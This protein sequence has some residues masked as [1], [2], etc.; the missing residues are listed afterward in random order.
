MS[1]RVAVLVIALSSVALAQQPARD[2]AGQR[3]TGTATISGIVM[4][5]EAQ[6]K[7]V[8]RAR[9]TLNSAE[10][11]HGRTEITHDDGTF[12]FRGLPAGQYRVGVTKDA[13]LFTNYGETRPGRPGTPIALRAGES[14]ELTLRL[15]RGSVITGTVVTADGQP[16]PG[17]QV[18]AFSMRYIPALGERRQQP[19]AMSGL[20]DD[21][22]VYRIFRLAPGDYMVAATQMRPMSNP[23]ELQRLTDAEIRRALSDVRES[24]RRSTPGVPVTPRNVKPPPPPP[25]ARSLTYAPVYY[26]GTPNASLAGRVTLGKSEERSGIDITVDFVPTARVG[27]FVSSSVQGLQG[28]VVTVTPAIGSSGALEVFRATSGVQPDGSFSVR[29]VPPG[30]YTVVARATLRPS[31]PGGRTT[32][33]SASTEVVV[34]GED[35][36]NVL[37]M[38]EPGITIAGHVRFEGSRPAPPLRAVN[39][40]LPQTINTATSAMTTL[41]PLQLDANGRF[42]LERV[43]PGVYRLTG[44]IQ[45]MQT[46]LG[47]WWLKSIAV[48]GRELL[49]APLEFRRSTDAAVVTFSDRASLVSGVA[50]DKEGNAVPDVHVVVFSADRRMWFHNSRRVTAAMTDASGRYSIRNLP[51][52]NYFVV[53]TSDLEPGEWFDPVVLERLAAA[54]MRTSI[55]GY[56]ENTL[57]VAF[58][59]TR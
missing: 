42:V 46:P 50:R 37:L 52:G 31:A 15:T 22:G 7:P 2:T 47:G 45:G 56:E 19:A 33:L 51:P 21:R 36:G 16:V 11:P 40:D 1:L 35:V 5:D 23:R 32:V 30:P 14:R 25:P 44:R 39:I 29:G 28:I 41:P 3:R 17:V 48:E 55:E 57:D 59:S 53:A 58:A 6:S 43:M 10:L 24:G 49:D 38:L 9:V 54:A 13:Y 20:T 18:L 26:P 27:G 8:R 12:A 34:D 4:S